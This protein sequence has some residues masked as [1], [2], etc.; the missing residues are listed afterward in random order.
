MKILNIEAVEYS[1]RAKTMLS[2]VGQYS[3]AAPQNEN[4][5]HALLEDVEILITRLKFN[6]N[7]GTLNAATNLRAI[8]TATTGLDHIDL[9]NAR[10]VE[11]E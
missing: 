7:P 2:D 6:I 10:P 4:E 11:F 5:L 9:R 8:A 3:E 1:G